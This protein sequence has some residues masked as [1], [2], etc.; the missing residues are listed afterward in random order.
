MSNA[1]IIILLAIP[2]IVL[3]EVAHGWTAWKLGDSTAKRMGRLTLNPIS[4]I[5][6]VGTIAVPIF[7]YLVYFFGLTHTLFMFGWAKP[8]PVDFQA[9]R[10]PKAGKILVALAGPASNL[11]LAFV[12][13]Q[14]LR[15]GYVPGLT[16]VLFWGVLLNLTL[17]VFNMIPIPPLDGS[18]VVSGFLPSS[19]DRAYNSIEPFGVIIVVVLLNLG[20]FD[21]IEHVITFL[22]RLIGL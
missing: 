8:V 22:M 12:F 19:M 10:N 3:H 16:E 6:P 11:I 15:S 18:R 20:W 1:I 17:A 5:D 2:A 4:H 14:M 9:L 13:A 7:L 21:G